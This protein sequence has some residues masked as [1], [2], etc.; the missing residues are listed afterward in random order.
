[1]TPAYPPGTRVEWDW[2][3]GR[4]QGFVTEVFCEPVGRTLKGAQVKR[5]A[6][7]D[8]PAYLIRHDSGSDVLKSHSELREA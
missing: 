6:S 1:M 2:G 3:R 7:P 5:N 8:N 4:A